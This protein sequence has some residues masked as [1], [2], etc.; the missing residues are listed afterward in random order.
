MRRY[1]YRETLTASQAALLLGLDRS[2]IIRY[3]KIGKLKA[4][5]REKT[6]HYRINFVELIAFMNR[7][8]NLWNFHRLNYQFF[9]VN[10]KP[11]WLKQKIEQDKLK[12]K[13]KC[14]YADKEKSLI[15]SNISYKSLSYCLGR[16]INA[17]KIERHRLLKNAKL[18]SFR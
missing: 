16:T 6:A 18:Y 3:I 12:K 15:K 4:C 9:W 2:T 5:Q 8:K 11:E 10:K 14:T 13:L 1:K 17:I 7:N